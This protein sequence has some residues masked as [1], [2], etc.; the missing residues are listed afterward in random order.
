MA[1][2]SN[3]PST[4]VKGNYFSFTCQSGVWRRIDTPQKEENMM[5]AIILSENKATAWITSPALIQ[6]N[7]WDHWFWS[8]SL[9]LFRVFLPQVACPFHKNSNNRV[10][11]SKSW[12]IA[13]RLEFTES[14]IQM[15]L[16]C[17]SMGV[18]VLG[19]IR[20]FLLSMAI[21]KQ[22]F[23]HNVIGREYRDSPL[24]YP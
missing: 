6:P 14:S 8:S 21:N 1:P 7:S 23:R 5:E 20:C 18:C 15:K 19:S 22:Y 13:W 4:S 17:R 2:L 11:S 12:S 10:W 9:P 16:F 3:S 24:N